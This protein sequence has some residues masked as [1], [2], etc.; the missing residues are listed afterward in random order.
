[1][2]SSWAVGWALSVIVYTAVFSFVPQD[3]AWRVL[4][5]TGAIPA[6]LVFYIRRNVEDA[7]KADE[8]RAT[9]TRKG[10]FR[11]I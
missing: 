11:E 8:G 5:W 6:V 10:S 2:Q 7:P 3:T 1:M 4:F 9:S